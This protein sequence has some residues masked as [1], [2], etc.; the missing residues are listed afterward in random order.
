MGPPP[1]QR[2]P[3]HDEQRGRSRALSP[4]APPTHWGGVARHVYRLPG[5]QLPK[6]Q[7]LIHLAWSG[8]PHLRFPARLDGQL[9]VQVLDILDG[10]ARVEPL[11]H[12]AQPLWDLLVSTGRLDALT[13]EQAHELSYGKWED[14]ILGLAAAYALQSTYPT[15]LPVVLQNLR[16]LGMTYPD[17][18]ILEATSGLAGLNDA[19]AREEALRGLAAASVVPVLRWGV[20][21]ARLLL[22]R[23]PIE[24]FAN[25]DSFLAGI[26]RQ[27]S[28][29]SIWTVW[30][31][32]DT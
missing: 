7:R 5:G 2:I 31:S 24:V 30:S 3:L 22:A 9:G 21:L 10:T 13:P 20:P 17:I 14:P 28:A 26:E 18:V 4:V 6:S 19:G 8:G 27:L 15:I 23:H 1:L 29:H 12:F 25:W 11:V 16:R 32:R